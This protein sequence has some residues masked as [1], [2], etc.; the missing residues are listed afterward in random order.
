MVP[1][2]E[3]TIRLPVTA[4]A[5]AVARGDRG[6][7]FEDAEADGTH[8]VPIKATLR[9]AVGKGDGEQVA[10]RLTERYS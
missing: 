3:Q 4:G 10:V 6:A 8:M 2:S 9:T 1:P 5:L 7:F